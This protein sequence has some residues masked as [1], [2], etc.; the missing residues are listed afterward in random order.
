MVPR[1]DGLAVQ[2]LWPAVLAA[3]VVLLALLAGAA[4]AAEP[5]LST[6]N[7][8]RE[9]SAFRLSSTLDAA[10]CPDRAAAQ[11]LPLAK[12]LKS[13]A[14]LAAKG[15]G[16][17]PAARLAKSSDGKTASSATAAGAGALAGGEPNAALLALL[18][19]RAL[20]PKNPQRLDSLAGVL[21]ML[22]KPRLAVSMSAAA[23]KLSAKPTTPMGISTKA[24]A[25]NNRGQALL[26]LGHFDAAEKLLRQSVSLAPL[27]SE[28][29]VNLAVALKCQGV[30]AQAARFFRAGQYRQ[31]YDMVVLQPPPPDF[32]IPRPQAVLDMRGGRESHLPQ[33][34]LPGG[35]EKMAG[36]LSAWE[37][38]QSQSQ[39]RA[40]QAGQR[41]SQLT[42]KLYPDK[43]APS[44]LRRLEQI[45][46][47]GSYAMV[48]QPGLKQL[49]TKWQAADH[50]VYSAIQGYGQ[51]IADAR[52]AC[53]G[54]DPCYQ[55]QCPSINADYHGRWLK[56]M[57][58]FVAAG[59]AEL[60]SS[61]RF[62]SALA[63]NI[64]NPTAHALLQEYL[65]LA[66]VSGVEYSY[67]LSAGS[68]WA[69]SLRDSYCTGS[70]A[71]DTIKSNDGKAATPDA[72]APVLRGVKFSV[73][74]GKLFKFSTNCEAFSAEIAASGWIGPYGEGS[75]DFVKG[76]GTVVVGVKGSVKIPETNVGVSAKEGIYFSVDGSGRVDTGLRA[77]TGAA[78]GASTGHSIDIKGPGYS[79]S[80]VSQTITFN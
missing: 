53:A 73:K 58:A 1:V 56:A 33:L 79:L 12:A 61:S 5:R 75:Y 51:A 77:S 66:P 11:P 78:F 20:E 65:N 31:R 18:R 37:G 63:A 32:E 4:N 72:C 50:N 45:R 74:I 28:A 62:S 67:L 30:S 3:P 29:K 7:D 34:N 64:A 68:F 21:N 35:W 54:D 16:K 71:P 2:R 41:I 26:D 25:L 46:T 38:L 17:G 22:G 10:D 23:A 13:A 47:A 59:A 52:H 8:L 48:L 39:A 55:S 36:S 9:L 40:R 60:K 15:G 44:I 69:Q 57:D 80:F 70:T 24:T 6:L 49:N 43:V 14:G 76:K 42:A 19:A 27:L